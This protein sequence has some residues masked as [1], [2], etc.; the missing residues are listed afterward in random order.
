MDGL[1]AQQ[2]YA[3]AREASQE[4]LVDVFGAS[5]LSVPIFKDSA[6]R[7]RAHNRLLYTQQ[8]VPAPPC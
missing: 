1:C 7:S 6:A 4:T 5:L 3:C 2:H 8:A